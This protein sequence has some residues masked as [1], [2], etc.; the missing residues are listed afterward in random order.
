MLGR[1]LCCVDLPKPHLTGEQG[2]VSRQVGRIQRKVLQCM[3]E[4]DG[5]VV[6]LFLTVSTQSKCLG[7]LCVMEGAAL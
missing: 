4:V 6:E 2:G 3:S 5:G 7:K 1:Y